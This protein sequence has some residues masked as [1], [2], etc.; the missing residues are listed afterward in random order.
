[1][2][3]LNALWS[4]G[5]KT[6]RL[7]LY[8]FD[9][10]VAYNRIMSRHT[11]TEER[12]RLLDRC[13]AEVVAIILDRQH[14][15][16]GL[17]PA[18]T[19]VNAHG[20]YTDAWVRDNVYSV[21]AAWGL[22]LAY[23]RL[24][25]A[26][27]RAYLLEQSTVKLMRGL[28][29]AMMKQADKVET[30]KHTQQ[31]HK[32][33][34]AKYDTQTG[35]VVVGDLEWGHLQIDATS[36]FLLM[37]AQMTGSGLRIVFN[38]DEVDFVQNLV[39]YVGRA[40]R[41]PDYGIWERGQ[42]INIGE[43]EL[44]T[45]SVGMAKAALEALS[46]FD[47]F[48]GRGGRGS[49]IHVVPD[50]IARARMTLEALLPRESG[51]K[52][53][54]AATLS[55]I[56]FPA[57]AV[58]NRTLVERTQSTVVGRL[59]GRYG[60]KRF[61]LDGHQTVLEEA[62]RL[63]YESDELQQFTD[64]ESEWPLFF[65]YLYLNHVF[66][67]DAAGA[68]EYREKLEGLLIEQDQHRLLPE[69]YYVPAE[70]V[71]AE[72]AHPR[73]QT[74]LPNENV[75][76]VW[77]QSLYLLGT[78]LEDGLLAPSD[79][80]PLGRRLRI[81]RSPHRRIQIAVLAE[82]ETARNGLEG[83]GILAE[84]LE[85]IRPV[86]VRQADDLA[87][88]YTQL[89]ANTRL[90]LSG[91]PLRR[92]R[93][94]S[95][96]RLYTLADRQV[97]FLPQFMNREDFYL[98][99]D[100]RMLAEQLKMTMAYV[101][102]HWDQPGKPLIVVLFSAD[103]LE[104]SGSDLLLDLIRSL[105]DGAYRDAPVQV[106]KLAQFLPTAGHSRIVTPGE[107]DLALD[108]TPGERI[109]F[110]LSFDPQ[111]TA[112]IGLAELSQYG[113]EANDDWLLEIL[114]ESANLYEHLEVLRILHVRH[115]PD[116]DTGLRTSAGGSGR[117]SDLLEEVYARACQHRYWAIVRR[118]AALLGKFS[119]LLVDAVTEIVV[120]QSRLTVGWAYSAKA[121]IKQPLDRHAILDMIR[122]FG[123]G[124]ERQHLLTQE[125]IVHLGLLATAE[126]ELFQDILTLRV[127]HM[128]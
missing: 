48:G 36:V 5:P 122:E 123:G 42:K 34:H 104:E 46:G 23:R 102:R 22:G 18:S 52:E 114:G 76:L 105:Q 2:S 74:R 55:V 65:T 44:N 83:E 109:E 82:D 106:G 86:Q 128:I 101:H 43:P 45:S 63:H 40:Y 51:S 29:T 113:P 17:L 7:I 53:T 56:G 70:N 14:P 62:G 54:D 57:F 110:V 80:D 96:S 21:L 1:M 24:D 68:R 94:L 75:P 25:E 108:A 103:M 72:K 119:E 117:V 9:R 37:L 16:T 115:E 12:Q 85:Q 118:T 124:D 93:A 39:H 126:P 61:L 31:P 27:E 91:R 64:I 107:L 111:Q 87:A 19:A 15:I 81:G 38:L 50:E 26:E 59:Q 78:L 69:L 47:L 20:D 11:R 112:S 4:G 99:L 49:V 100:D 6:Y 33:L 32:A 66:A 67:D 95:T 28:L 89:G 3:L 30:F 79:I 97:V 71:D 92:M 98:G 127:G 10:R 120:T 125:V 90:G 60:C 116:F 73:S 77:A 121:T 41:T 88:T 35:D 58:E 8:G 13:F 84:T